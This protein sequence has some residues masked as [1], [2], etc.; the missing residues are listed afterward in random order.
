MKTISK[1]EIDNTEDPIKIFLD[2][3]KID[4]N[5]ITEM[6]IR[7]SLDYK[8]LE[9]NTTETILIRTKEKQ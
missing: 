7:L 8:T 2:G 1:I 4:L 3:K 9:I 5:G 6:N